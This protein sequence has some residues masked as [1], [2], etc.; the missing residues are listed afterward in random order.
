ADDH[1]WIVEL[2]DDHRREIATTARG[3]TERGVDPA[4]VS[5][6]IYPLPGMAADLAAWTGELAAG[7]G[8][9]LLRGF[10][11]DELT[12]TE[13]EIAYLGLG[14]HLGT[15]VGQNKAG[16][17]LTHIRDERLADTTGVRLY[18][19]NHRQDFH[20]DGADIIG[21][22]C[23][24]RAARGGQSRIAST[25]AI[26]NEILS[27]R[28]DLLE[29][30]HQPM[31]W[32]RQGEQ[33]DG[34]SPWFELAPLADHDGDARVFYIGWYIRDAQQH[35]DA[36]RLRDDQLEAMALIEDIANDP[37]FHIEMDFQPGDI[38]LLNNARIL[39]SREAYDDDPD[40]ARRRHLLRLW[41]AAHAFTA[42]EGELRAGIGT[43]AR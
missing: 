36:P 39:H 3:V 31:A 14:A 35:P 19:T 6:D 2:T 17:V 7:R 18:R 38:Q 33:A 22:L 28:P 23:L 12:D 34:E 20:T 24:Y 41:L 27:R 13:I 9:L 4:A 5:A 15:P 43:T 1:R 30:L 32:D 29:V 21:L 11:I 37:A 8:F 40:P 16:D 25:G 10:P 26:Y 42:V